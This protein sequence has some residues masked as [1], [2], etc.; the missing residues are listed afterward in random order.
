MNHCVFIP[1]V[2]Y[3]LASQLPHDLQISLSSIYQGQ[4]ASYIRN[5][6]NCIITFS[7]TFISTGR[8]SSS[9]SAVFSVSKISISACYEIHYKF[10]GMNYM[11]FKSK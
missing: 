2:R 8:P 9:V 5:C 3:Q 10:S 4:P 6:M 1:W 11:V 7:V